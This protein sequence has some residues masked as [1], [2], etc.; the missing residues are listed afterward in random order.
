M[1]KVISM[2]CVATL[3]LPVFV[4]SQE[5]PIVINEICWMGSANSA[6]DEWVELFNPGQTAINLEGWILKTA[7]DGIK[8]NLKGEIPAKG[9]FLLERTDDNSAPDVKA[10]LIYSGA[11]SNNDENVIL[12]DNSGNVIDQANFSAGWPNGNNKTKQTME[13]IVNGGPS[14]V[15]WPAS[16]ASR[17][18]AG[19]Q[20]SQIPGGTPKSANSSNNQEQITNNETSTIDLVRT[21]TTQSDANQSDRYSLHQAENVFIN[22]IMPSPE[23][24]DAENEWLELYNANNFAVDLAGWKIKDK[25]GAT[26]TYIFPENTKISANRFLVLTRPQSKISL[27]NTGDGVELL[28]PSGQIIDSVDFEKAKQ[29]QSLSRTAS[30][31]QW[32]ATPT[33]EKENIITSTANLKTNTSTSSNA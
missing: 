26:K 29:G 1:S 32:T 24:D 21:T 7:D 14:P 30:T 20:T 6:N 27:N 18:D 31:W 33:P 13:R 15:S 3:F 11:L 5:K 17:S 8:I 19:W 28:N 2:L 12:I 9:F 10:D 16:N 25:I 4:F 23:G 22:E